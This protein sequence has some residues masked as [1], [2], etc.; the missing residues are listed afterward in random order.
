MGTVLWFTGLSGAGKST[1]AQALADALRRRQKTVEILDGDAVRERI[2]THLGFSEADIKENNRLVAGF[3]KESATTHDFVLVPII[4]PFSESRA[5]ARE[6]VGPGF[7]E[8]YV[9]SSHETRAA[10]DP[11]GLY[12]KMAAGELQD[13]IGYG[14]VPYEAPE[15][16]DLTIL[17]DSTPLAQ[18]VEQV[19]HYL[20]L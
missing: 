13:F 2:H 10:R 11:K 9:A 6:I 19:L 3:A 17:T 7:S 20:S 15:H 1:I 16:P 5:L 14:G 4:S 8:I 18:S 12:K